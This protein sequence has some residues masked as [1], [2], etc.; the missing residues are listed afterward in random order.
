MADQPYTANLSF[1]HLA[2]ARKLERYSMPEPN[3]GC[4]LWLR[5][6]SPQ[7]Y[8]HIKIG[9]RTTRLA[10]RVAY[11]VAFGP[12]PSGLSVC[13]KCDVPS[14]INPNHLFLGTNADNVADKVAKGRATAVR[15]AKHHKARL[16][17]TQVVAIRADPRTHKEIAVA[18]GVSRGAISSIKA[19]TSWGYV[20]SPCVRIRRVLDES[21]GAKLTTKLVGSIRGM[22]CPT[23]VMAKMFSVDRRTIKRIQKRE[24][25]KACP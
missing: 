24:I 11:H 23:D 19:A 2:I 18:Y 20:E 14:C 4:I 6:C 21:P 17:K 16:T 22:T 8:G 25:W 3:S 5:G 1:D 7:G 15:G 12:I 10:H 13:H 9:P